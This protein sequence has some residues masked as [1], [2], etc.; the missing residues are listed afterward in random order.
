MSGSKS[1]SNRLLVMDAL[2]GNRTTFKNLS[3]AE[4]TVQMRKNLRGISTCGSSRIPM[5]VDAGHAGTVFRFLTAFLSVTKGRWL[6]T[7]IDRMKNRPIGDMVDALQELGADIHY[8]EKKSFPPLLINGK[9]INGG[10]VSI[11]PSKSS[12]FVT[13]LMLIAPI[14]KNGLEITLSKT[15]VSEAYI[16]MTAELMK[17][18]GIS[19]EVS[20]GKIDI[21]PGDYKFDQLTVE[22]DWS[23]ASYW[24]EVAALS[25]NCD[26]YLEGFKKQSIQGDCI[27]ADL[28]E[29]FGVETVFEEYGIRLKNSNKKINSFEF[30][31]TSY[32]DLVPAVMATCTAK[33]IQATFKGVSHLKYKESDRLK[34]LESELT[35]TGVI[36]EKANEGVQLNFTANKIVSDNLVFDTYNDHRIAM[37]VAPL[38][39]VYEK[40]VI[41]NP[42]V[43][44]KSYPSFWDDVNVSGLAEVENI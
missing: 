40:M 23:S 44:T 37:C 21:G 28:F 27:C 39:S 17:Q 5:V 36:F 4:D 2:T 15:P 22:P 14:L 3:D 13:A 38:V 35:K 16:L 43:V 12:Q 19:L 18:C 1:I 34:S 29:R 42:E 24:Y 11:D 25:K 32:P 30:D 26:I 7:G 10:K 20:E 8:T 33:K 9:E 31:F 6:I 41:N